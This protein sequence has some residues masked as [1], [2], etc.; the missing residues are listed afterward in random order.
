M[1]EE[2]EDTK[3][4]ITIRI[5]KKNR[6][7]NDQKE[8]V[9][10]DKQR[11]TKHTHKTK[12]WV[13]RTPLNTGGEL[14]SL[15]R[16]SSSCSTSGNRRVNLVINPVIICEWGKDRGVLA[17]SGTCPW[18]FVTQIFHTFN[19]VIVMIST[20]SKGT[21][22]SVASLLAAIL[23]QGNPDR[24][25]WFLKD[26]NY[27]NFLLKLVIFTVA[28]AWNGYQFARCKGEYTHEKKKTFQRRIIL[29]SNRECVNWPIGGY[30]LYCDAYKQNVPLTKLF[31]FKMVAFFVIT[32]FARLYVRVG[33]LLTFGKHMDNPSV[34]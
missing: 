31:M 3:G 9:Q 32:L 6:Q 20:L 10:K 26:S 27:K 29:E 19:Q 4:V 7:H 25:L 21:L 12:D 11:S 2:F 5:S 8:K 1:W 22:G 18:T 33:I 17:T 23:Y 24:N 16:V 34:N 14:G 15:G 30:W 13:T 28:L